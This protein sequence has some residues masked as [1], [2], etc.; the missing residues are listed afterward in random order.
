LASR[1]SEVGEQPR[2]MLMGGKDGRS[3]LSIPGRAA[4]VT[5]RPR[6]AVF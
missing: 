2:T 3:C 1:A 5:A 4:G 6:A